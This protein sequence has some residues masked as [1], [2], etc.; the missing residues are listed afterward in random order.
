[1]PFEG[2][3]AAVGAGQE[4]ISWSTVEKIV[5]FGASSTVLVTTTVDPG[6]VVTC[7]LTVTVDAGRTEV[8]VSTTGLA[9]TAVMGRKLVSV[10]RK[11][12]FMIVVDMDVVVVSWQFSQRLYSPL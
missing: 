10:V 2:T 4:E 12:A 5:T 11:V 7:P 9:V 6:T 3:E 8:T 1:M